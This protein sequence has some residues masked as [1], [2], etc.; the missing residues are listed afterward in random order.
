MV[1]KKSLFPSVQFHHCLDS[2][3][4]RL[5]GSDGSGV[6]FNAVGRDI[7]VVRIRGV[8][9]TAMSMLLVEEVALAAPSHRTETQR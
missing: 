7:G 3:L 4:G 6:E 5:V 2:P 9:K 1:N 8:L